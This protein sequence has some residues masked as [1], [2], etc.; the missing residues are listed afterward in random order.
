M[1]RIVV[2]A[3]LLSGCSLG[4]GRPATTPQPTLASVLP[5]LARTPPYRPAK[6]APLTPRAVA[7]IA[8]EHV[9]SPDAAF[10]AQDSGRSATLYYEPAPG[11]GSLSLTV[12]FGRVPRLFT[13]PGDQG[14]A[15][16]TSCAVSGRLRLVWQEGETGAGMVGFVA[17][18][19][20]G[21]VMV[22]LDGVTVEGR[23]SS[24]DLPIPLREL[25][26]VAGDRRLDRLTDRALG[27]P[28]RTRGVWRTDPACRHAQAQPLLRITEG[29]DVLGPATPRGLAAL[30]ATRVVGVAAADRMT[31]GG[32]AATLFRTHDDRESVTAAVTTD[33]TAGTCADGSDCEER[34][35]ALVTWSLDAPSDQAM[36]VQVARPV[37]G[38][39]LVLTE[40]SHRADATTRRFPVPLEALLDL[41]RDPRFGLEMSRAV[42]RAGASLP[43][44]W[45]VSP[46]TADD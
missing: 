45:R 44:C 22:Q 11:R 26:A 15:P 23:P 38:G 29:S 6:P 1:W 33:P 37:D 25:R 24:A 27:R 3:L 4:S 19:A 16:A 12:S 41:S 9:G 46:V 13:C 43:Q 35:G 36:R 8:I 18:R 10:H 32:V 40:R 31:P 34:D 14:E 17:G 20:H 42:I 5:E 39:Y 30:V 28:G 21:Q 2:L 7:A